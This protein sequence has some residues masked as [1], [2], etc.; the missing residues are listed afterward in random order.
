MKLHRYV[1]DAA[2]GEDCP[3]WLR[4]VVNVKLDGHVSNIE[5][6]RVVVVVVDVDEGLVVFLAEDADVAAAA[7]AQRQVPALE[8][9]HADLVLAAL[10]AGMG[11][12]WSFLAGYLDCLFGHLLAAAGLVHLPL[13]Q[14]VLDP[15]IEKLLVLL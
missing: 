6:S 4:D 15:A 9:Q 12:F 10:E 2:K 14:L 11:Q 13:Q 7:F 5:R 3:C 8:V 1:V